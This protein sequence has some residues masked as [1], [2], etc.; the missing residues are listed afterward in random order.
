[1]KSNQG[2]LSNIYRS[3]NVTTYLSWHHYFAIRYYIHIVILIE[4]MYQICIRFLHNHLPT[5]NI[6]EMKNYRLYVSPIILS[7][8]Y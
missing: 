1:M 5:N 3:R 2:F 6:I 4:F 7:I 8:I